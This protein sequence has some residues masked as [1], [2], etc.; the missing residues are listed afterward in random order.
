MNEG[1]GSMAV[2][3][4]IIRNAPAGAVFSLQTDVGNSF[5]ANTAYIIKLL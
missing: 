1:W 5:V 4:G 3:I 2:Y